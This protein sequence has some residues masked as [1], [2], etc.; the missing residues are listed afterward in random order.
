MTVAGRHPLE[1]AA[2]RPIAALAVKTVHSAVFLLEL[3]AIGWLV[4]N[5]F[6]GL[7]YWTVALA[8]GAV[9]IEA[10]VFS[11]NDRV[12]PLT[13]LA[14]R[15][16]EDRGQVSDR[17]L[18]AAIARTILIWSTAL[19]GIAVVLHAGSVLSAGQEP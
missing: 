16:G 19:V 1:V 7:L 14:E 6:L 15:L 9:A 5:G 12:C 2:W 10:A 4:V 3:A 17:F 11:G 8:A 18:P 13:T